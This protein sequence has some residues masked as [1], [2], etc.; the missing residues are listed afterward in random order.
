MS[1]VAIWDS[2]DPFCRWSWQNT[3]ITKKIPREDR[4]LPLKSKKKKSQETTKS[5]KR[6]KR[7]PSSIK[8]KI[9]K[10]HLLLRVPNFARWPLQIRF[11]CSDVHEIWQQWDKQ[12]D[13][14]IRSKTNTI[15]DVGQLFEMLKE[16]D[17]PLSKHARGKR[18]QEAI[19]KGGVSGLDV[20]YSNVKDHT[21]KSVR[22]L[23][24]KNAHVGC[25]ICFEALGAHRA[26][27]LVCRHG[28]CQTVSHM[29]CLA[30]AFL[31]G[32]SSSMSL[33]PTSGR[34]PGCK[35]ET[36]WVDLI[37]EMTLRTRGSKVVARLMRKSKSRQNGEQETFAQTATSQIH[38]GTVDF[39]KVADL[40][41][42]LL[43]EADAD[44]S[45][46][47]D[48]QYQDDDADT[49]STTSVASDTSD[50]M[51]LGSPKKLYSASQRLPAVI[52]DSEWDDAEVLD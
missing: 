20:G 16:G 28:E 32:E 3:H 36:Q 26:T 2:P 39:G 10:L 13:V 17:K 31:A 41:E 29:N 14:A 43:G 40:D 1:N 22:L 15:L 25:A 33:M 35:S 21:E 49:M 9:S 44:D 47:D 42:D 34:C 4:L 6:P 23:S 11:F 12:I 38:S 37:K 18:N 51:E 52:E 8:D 7:P 48:W 24:D 50:G 46:P 45:L 5:R 19:G 30:K 27:A